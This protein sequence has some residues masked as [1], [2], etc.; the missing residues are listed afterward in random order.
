MV[1]IVKSIRVFL[2]S[3]QNTLEIFSNSEYKSKYIGDL[4]KFW[5]QVKIHSNDDHLRQLKRL[6]LN[7]R[8][9]K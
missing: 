4:F 7:I 2:L 8:K 9:E 3:H 6:V 5:I 1:K